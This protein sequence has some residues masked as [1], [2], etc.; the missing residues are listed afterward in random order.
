MIVGAL[1]EDSHEPLLKVKDE[2][3]GTPF[4]DGA[5]LNVLGVKSVTTWWAIPA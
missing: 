2:K 5:I 3:L 1:I 4:R